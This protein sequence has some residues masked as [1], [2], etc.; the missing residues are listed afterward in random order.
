MPSRDGFSYDASYSQ[1]SPEAAGISPGQRVR[2]PIFGPG[3]VVSTSGDGPSQKLK[4]QFE[5]AGVKT[6]VLKYANLELG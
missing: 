1:E 4:V 6:L 3:V 2:H 5:R